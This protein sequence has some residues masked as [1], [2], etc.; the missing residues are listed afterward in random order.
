MTTMVVGEGKDVRQADQRRCCYSRE[1]LESEGH[2]DPDGTEDGECVRGGA[3]HDTTTSQQALG[4][5]CLALFGSAASS[6]L[7]PTPTKSLGCSTSTTTSTQSY[8]AASCAVG[9]MAHSTRKPLTTYARRRPRRE[10][11]ASDAT[12]S[13]P[14]RPLDPDAEDVTVAEMAT[15]M[16]KR[17]RHVARSA[18]VEPGTTANN[19]S[20]GA[21]HEGRPPKRL[22]AAPSESGAQP[23]DSHY[24]RDLIPSAG[25]GFCTPHTPMPSDH[26]MVPSSGSR[27]LVPLDCFSP[28]PAMPLPRRPISTSSRNLKE[29]S[30][31]RRLASPFNSRPGS[32]AVSPD[33]SVRAR[34]KRSVHH[35]KSRTLSQSGALREKPV[36]CNTIQ[37][38]SSALDSHAFPASRVQEIET[39][40]HTKLIAPAHNRSSST[41]TVKPVLD[42]VSGPWLVPPGQ[43]ARSP[44]PLPQGSPGSH[45]NDQE[46]A[47]HLS[48]FADAPRQIS[49]PPQRR[50]SATIGVWAHGLMPPLDAD[51]PPPIRSFRYDSDVDMSDTSPHSS[52]QNGKINRANVPRRRRRTIVHLSSDS[53]FSSSFDF[54][55]LMS[56]TERFPRPPA[57]EGSRS[58]RPQP[59]QLELES[60]FSPKDT[61]PTSSRKIRSNEID[62][63]KPYDSFPT[64]ASPDL[65][66]D[67]PEPPPSSPSSGL[68]P[69][70]ASP[71]PDGDELLDLFSVL[72]LDGKLRSPQQPLLRF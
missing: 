1:D 16:N 55:G 52:P 6:P 66:I 49:T 70:Q 64:A 17:A 45:G 12:R 61:K 9:L 42:I 34:T 35:A 69:A 60:P 44:S 11:P 22:K 38:T 57:S 63:N 28:F 15:R 41:P 72:G 71:D 47:D 58:P 8:A 53:L 19:P 10:A 3:R 13:S 27:P 32:R 48:F 18:S 26:S 68:P 31:S 14:I 24:M 62:S 56:E 39:T 29:N 65:R 37:A 4:V 51:P 36:D 21:H 46:I 50:R 25:S 67:C 7:T 59:D 54:S 40:L 20:S 2:R 33:K 5:T 23:R 43:L 30:G